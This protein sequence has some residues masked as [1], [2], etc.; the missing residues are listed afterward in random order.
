MLV[1]ATEKC[2]AVGFAVVFVSLFSFWA[3]QVRAGWL[4]G[5]R[6]SPTSRRV[7]CLQAYLGA[8]CGKEILGSVLECTH[9][10]PISAVFPRQQSLGWWLG[11]CAVGHGF[12]TFCYE[13][14]GRGYDF[15]NR[16]WTDFWMECAVDVEVVVGCIL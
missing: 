16:S 9:R 8:Q 12:G 6:G 1:R 13:F 7:D 5:A 3:S 10:L 15:C 2:I 4:L 14:G 11:L